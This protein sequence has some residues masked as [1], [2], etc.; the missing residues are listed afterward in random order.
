MHWYQASSV[1][2][3]DCL[4][5]KE[6]RV[7]ASA[8]EDLTAPALRYVP[9]IFRSLSW[10]RAAP[11]RHETLADRLAHVAHV[12][13]APRKFVGYQLDSITF[14]AVATDFADRTVQ[15]VKFEWLSSNPGNL[16]IDE[17]GRATFLQPGLVLVTC[18]A[19]L[20]ANIAR[21]LIRP[22]RRPRQTDSEW[23]ADQASLI[24]DANPGGAAGVAASLT[25]S[26]VDTLAPTAYAQSGGAYIGND[27]IYD[28]LW[29]EPRNLTGS[30]GSRAVEVTSVGAAMPEG[31]NY[32]FA[33]PIV[34]LGGRGIGASLTL[35]HNSR[36]WGR[37]G[38]A[39]TFDP[40]ASWPSPGYSL[41][42]G[43]VIPYNVEYSGSI[44][45]RARYML[46]EPDGTRHYL[47]QSGWEGWAPISGETTDGSHIKISGGLSGM[48]LQ[49]K[50]G[51]TVYYA[52]INNRLLPDWIQD[53]NGNYITVAYATSGSP[54]A[55]DYI[56]DTLGRIIQFSYDSGGKLTGIIAPGFG[57]TVE[58]PVTR[59]LA[60]FDYQ[61]L[62][63]TNSFSGLTVENASGTIQALR[64]IYYPA[65]NTGY[66]LSSSVYGMVY[67]YSMRRAMSI[68]GLV[69]ADGTESASVN[70]NY[71]TTASSLT[72]AP[73][74][75]Q[76]VESAV[77]S[78]TAT[79]T[80]ST[81]TDTFAQTMTFTVTQPDSTTLLLTRSTNS[82]IP[83]NGRL[84]QSEIK[85]GSTS[86][87][88]SVFNYVNDPGGSPQV[89]SVTSY[90]DAAIAIKVDFDYD[91]YGNLTNKREY[92]Y[93]ISGNWQVRRRTHF[94]Y[95]TGSAYV[96]IG[97]RGLVTLVE[98]FD[99]LQN[100][101]DADDVLIAKTSY[102]YDNYVAMGG[103]EDYGGL[104][105]PPGHSSSY[106][107]SYTTRGN[108]TGVTDWTDLQLGTTVQHLAKIDI[109]G[110]V[111][112]AQVSCCQEKALT[113]SDATY[114]SQPDS[115]ISGDP[116]SEHTTTSTD[117]DFNTD[118]AK[119][120]TNAAGLVTNIGYNAA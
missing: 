87:G 46:I 76:R 60:Q 35:Y 68:N 25:A 29:S 66:L 110:N 26:L 42:F 91:A 17:T 93:Q 41:G 64:H 85:I 44:P 120:Q 53:S 88:K 70:L 23:A 115:E 57:G 36:V 118:L 77:S 80:Y 96:S 92:G 59:T 84:I 50:D 113:N 79:Y 56:T 108:V 6:M 63:V 58:D 73:A 95:E 16:E 38:S 24:A 48:L 107:T 119:S 40:I 13:I 102:A 74:F 7:L 52:T 28:E 27:F 61:S 33:L 19:G 37:H 99:T 49:F 30:P 10:F 54:L 32:E 72:D 106:P 75:T 62:T 100:T 71:P 1:L 83:A 14:T 5:F 86:L 98:I 39:V 43:R 11:R 78:P 3:G 22:G 94:T 12:Q 109:F 82:A 69:I 117:Y 112:K 97:L 67:N 116:N 101:N 114:W 15:G 105:N 8:V 81:S 31:S 89:Q 104:A 21:V 47:G 111:V 55:I 45:F 103:M 65:T 18:R 90:D 51:T 4:P 20:V 9:R 2:P 34:S